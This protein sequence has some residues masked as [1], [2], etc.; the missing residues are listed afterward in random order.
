MNLYT[1]AHKKAEAFPHTS[2]WKKGMY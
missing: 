2:D 1:L